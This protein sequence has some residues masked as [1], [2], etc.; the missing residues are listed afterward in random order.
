MADEP[1]PDAEVTT[2]TAP[3]VEATPNEEPAA[4]EPVKP[5]MPK[6][7]GVPF[8]D[9]LRYKLL[10]LQ[11]RSEKAQL[12]LRVLLERKY[13]I[14]MME[15]FQQLCASKPELV[16]VREEYNTALNEVFEKL[17]G[18]LPEGYAVVELNPE[19]GKV[20]AAHAPEQRG[21]KRF[22]V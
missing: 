16:K 17:E 9:A 22:A 3:E 19:Q 4:A 18:P 21:Q 8:P 13:T 5:E 10:A 12:A 7:F 20:V 2:T 11:T 14:L 1:T 6:V 15:E